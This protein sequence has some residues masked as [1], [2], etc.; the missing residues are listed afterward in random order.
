LSFF[1]GEGRELY[2]LEEEG[3]RGYNEIELTSGDIR[4]EGVIYY[5][6]ESGDHSAS[7][8]MVVIK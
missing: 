8:K 5:K 4:A 7:K 3:Q 1:D 2:I 6:L